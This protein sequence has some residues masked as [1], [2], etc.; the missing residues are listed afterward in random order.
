MRFIYNYQQRNF[1]INLFLKRCKF[2][3]GV[4]GLVTEFQLEIREL[5]EPQQYEILNYFLKNSEEIVDDTR[6]LGEGVIIKGSRASVKK[7]LDIPQEFWT[8]VEIV[9]KLGVISWFVG[10]LLDILSKYVNARL[11]IDGKDVP[12]SKEEIEKM[13]K[14][15]LSEKENTE[16]NE[17]S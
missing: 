2:H 1:W 6:K 3:K 16:N 10:K 17:P 11:R 7:V 5:K 8:T 12:I 4:I 15:I 14:K 13:I 9:T